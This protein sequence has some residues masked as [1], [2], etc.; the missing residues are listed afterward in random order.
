MF[1]IQVAQVQ[2]SPAHA[3]IELDRNLKYLYFYYCIKNVTQRIV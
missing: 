1:F 3:Q 2:I